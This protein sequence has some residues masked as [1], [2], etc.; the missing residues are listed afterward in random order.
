MSLCHVSAVA[1]DALFWPQL[2]EEVGRQVSQRLHSILPGFL[3]RSFTNRLK[4]A[5][6]YPSQSKF[7]GSSGRNRKQKRSQACVQSQ[8]PSHT[9]FCLLS[10]FDSLEQRRCLYRPGALGEAGYGGYISSYNQRPPIQVVHR[11]GLWVVLFTQ[12]TQCLLKQL[13]A[14]KIL[15]HKYLLGMLLAL[16]QELKIHWGKQTNKTAL[17]EL[18]FQ[19]RKTK[20]K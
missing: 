8:Y 3:L 16:F 15:S 4:F 20:N 6:L 18:T 19:Q 17:M 7:G 11:L 9:K 12:S 14:F 5:M 2:L 10:V 13:P 1:P